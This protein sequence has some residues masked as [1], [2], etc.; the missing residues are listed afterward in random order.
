M[1]YRIPPGYTAALERLRAIRGQYEQAIADTIDH[2]GAINVLGEDLEPEEDASSDDVGGEP[3]LGAAEGVTC[4]ADP[5]GWQSKRAL[6][7]AAD[8]SVWG[9]NGARWGVD[10]E[11]D[12]A[13]DEPSLGSP[14]RLPATTLGVGPHVDFRINQTDW[15]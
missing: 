7:R 3:S 9:G 8:Q 13:D 1:G 6:S 10:A 14:E 15:V 4:P 11:L 2:L 5:S 12:T